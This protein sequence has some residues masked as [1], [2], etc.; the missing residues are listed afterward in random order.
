[1]IPILHGHF[2]LYRTNVFFNDIFMFLN[3]VFDEVE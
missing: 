1:M 3:T 2:F